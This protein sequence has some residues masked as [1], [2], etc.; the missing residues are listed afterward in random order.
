MT[1][2]DTKPSRLPATAAVWAVLSWAVTL[3]Y[4][5]VTVGM[6]SW[7]QWAEGAGF[8]L[9]VAVAL[10]PAFV[11]TG[12]GIRTVWYG[13]YSQRHGVTWLGALATLSGLALGAV[14]FLWTSLAYVT[15]HGG[16]SSPS[17]GSSGITW[18]PRATLRLR[19]RGQA[20]AMKPWTMEQR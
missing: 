3:R 15:A 13:V 17:A 6:G 19:L 5:D 18:V 4:L 8:W 16:C 20:L 11:G 2:D 7:P 10:I 1:P 9:L 12:L 14:S